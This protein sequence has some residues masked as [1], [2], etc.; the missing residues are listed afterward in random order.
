MFDLL[1]AA[2]AALA[3]SALLAPVIMLA[4][5]RDAPDSARRAHRTATPT[6]GGLAVA[7]GFAG[8]LL[9][10]VWLLHGWVEWAPRLPAGAFDRA[11]GVV[12]AAALALALGTL[13]DVR[14]L[15]A[16]GK[17]LTGALLALALA[18]FVAHARTF[19]FGP[20]LVVDVGLALGVAGSAL[21]VFTL[22][23]SV[24]FMDG[25]NGMAMGSTTMGLIGL[26]LAA[27]VAGAWHAAALAGAG[28]GALIGFLLWNYPGGKIFAGDAG[29]LFAGALA[30][31]TALLAIRDGGLSPIVPPLL[32][33]PLLADVLLT[34]LW[35]VRNRKSAFEAHADHLYQIALR[36]GWSHARISAV[37]WAAT[38]HCAALGFLASLGPMAAQR[39][40]LEASG[41]AALA[42]WPA[43]LAPWIALAALA[44]LAVRVDGRVRRYALARG[45][46]QRD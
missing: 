4:G 41:L 35:R 29:A 16:R 46:L 7:A 34:L 36:A 37:Y 11:A 2:A 22:M 3:L 19:Q 42:I 31:G 24:N 39:W 26:A 25:A 8:G 17:F 45:L 1:L 38:A 40:S 23:N 5:P 10:L 30:A 15:P 43:A 33:F 13:D 18:I 27:S 9:L 32:F 28:A 44:L 21:W 12:G 6:S 14:Q 20:G